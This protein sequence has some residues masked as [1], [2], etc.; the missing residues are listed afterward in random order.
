MT[1]GHGGY[2]PSGEAPSART[3]VA[4]DPLMLSPDGPAVVAIGGGHGLAAALEAV[5]LYAGKVTAVVSVADDGGSS[6]RLIQGL[7]IPAPG[8]IRRCLLALTPE[9]TLVSELFAYR[10]SAG[11][12][13]DHS[14]GNLMLAALTDL[15]GD[16][17]AA[18]DAAGRMLGAL[19]EVIPATTS[20]VGLRARIDGETVE[21]Q[22]SISRL[23]GRI[24]AMELSPPDPQPNLRALE[25]IASADQVVIGPGSLFTS[26]I[27]A[28]VVPDLAKV[29]M[30]SGAR[31]VFVCNLVTQDGETWSLD[32]P[33]HIEALSRLGGVEGPGTIVVHDGHLAVPP[34][35]SRIDLSQPPPG[36][37]EVV[38]ADVADP[39]ADWPAHDPF[40][41]AQVLETLVP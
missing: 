16:F 38:R 33:G 12:V 13:M 30:A 11:D 14:L 2:L 24:E 6:G 31:R 40:A 37:W 27:A 26:V 28:L 36:G 22:V 41:L 21:G 32:G 17:G 4:D 10:F 35:H 29:V 20:P 9:P 5:Q 19:G 25:A 18:V 8:D 1:Y 39:T 23:R 7:S 34:G 3:A 15:Y